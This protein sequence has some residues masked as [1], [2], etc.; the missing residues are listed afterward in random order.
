[1]HSR[2]DVVNPLPSPLVFLA[3]SHKDAEKPVV[4]H[5]KTTLQDRGI[6]LWSAR[7]ISRQGNGR[8][9]IVLRDVIQAA[10]VILVVLSPQ[11]VSSR[12][13]REALDTAG[14]YERPMCG[15]WIEGE[16]LEQCL[17]EGHVELAALIDA[18]EKDTPTM[19]EETAKALEQVRLDSQNGTE[20]TQLSMPDTPTE[21][22]T[23]GNQATEFVAWS[24]RTV[25]VS[26]TPP[27]PREPT[28]AAKLL[29]GNRMGLSRTRMGLLIGLVILVIAGGILGSLT[30]LARYQET[31]AYSEA[32]TVQIV[33]GGTWIEDFAVDP[34]S[35]I[36]DTSSYPWA[37]MAQQALY[38]PLFYGDAHGVVHPGAATEIPTVR[39]GGVSADATT[40]T[41]HL[42]PHLL[43]SDGQPYDARDVAFTWK[44]IL[45]PTFYYDGSVPGLD[46]SST[47]VVSADHLSITFHLK[48]PYAPFLALWIDGFNAPLPAHH[49]SSMTP[50][51]I[52]KSADRLNPNVVSGPFMMS[53]S[54]PGDHYTFVRNPR[55]YLASEGLPYLDKVIIHIVP[56]TGSLLEDLQA[57]SIDLYDDINSQQV[58]ANP[59]AFEHFKHYRIVSSSTS[60]YFLGLF[61]NFKN[62]VLA[63]HVEV[64]EAMAMAIDHQAMIATVVHGFAE[65]ICTDH[66]S[67][68]HPG[69]EPNYDC[70]PF[71]P[72]AANKLLDDNGWVRGHDG[73][74][75]KGKER[76]EFELSSE[77]G[78]PIRLANEVI[79]QHD[80]SAIGIKLDIQNYGSQTFFGSFL[81]QGK[82]SPPTGAVAGR[83]D[84]AEFA[85]NPGTYDPDDS[86]FVPCNQYPYYCNS[87]LSPLYKQELET[88]DAGQRQ[89]IFSQIHQI[90]LTDFPF[91]PLY[92]PLDVSIARQGTHNYQPS[93]FSGET[94]NIWQWWC[95]NGKC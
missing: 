23:T 30:L 92:F 24:S 4:S 32:T 51:A 26:S 86:S 59:Q 89:Q 62:A 8:T 3:S 69:Y 11:A 56:T 41:F 2:G 21:T 5:L 49:F 43:W 81:P 27:R 7:Q 61:F 13:V 17:P 90:Y 48:Q 28:K 39:N 88:A 54:V 73:V 31:G 60:F 72:T 84:I 65:N 9:R 58:S 94:D 37:I 52:L 64:R 78:T 16:E 74:R 36:P 91:I 42:R 63:S 76:L 1:M 19:L 6:T 75:T 47:A 57:G 79:V 95:D 34:Y 38:L 12:H 93:P 80:L 44:L 71:D 14:R 55:Y 15:I 46:P 53:E 25:D 45:N 22:T 87:A 82:P 20:V 18:R 77:D 10:Q 66:G 50:Q 29:S 67:F 40:W 83:N 70:P 68:Y 33:R 35:L 85:D